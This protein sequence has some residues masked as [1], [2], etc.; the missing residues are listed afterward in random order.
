[1]SLYRGAMGMLKSAIGGAIPDPETLVGNA[2]RYMADHQKRV[3]IGVFELELKAA[4][5]HLKVTEDGLKQFAKEIGAEVPAPGN[6]LLAV[7]ALRFMAYQQ[8]QLGS[9]K[10]NVHVEAVANRLGFSDV[11]LRRLLMAVSMMNQMVQA[12]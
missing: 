2:V 3:G 1:M 8:R 7:V 12:A 4:A 6:E 11:E 5:D 9:V 10:F